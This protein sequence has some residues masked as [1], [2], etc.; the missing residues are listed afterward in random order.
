MESLICIRQGTQN[1]FKVKKV[2][3]NDWCASSPNERMQYPFRWNTRT[4]K[5]CINLIN[6]TSE[7][8]T[9]HRN[10][11]TFLVGMLYPTGFVHLLVKASLLH[12]F[13]QV[14]DLHPANNPLTGPAINMP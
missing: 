4:Y 2:D 1:L 6:T 10:C 9:M 12:H 8:L 5:I 3:E 11:T 13:L 14:T 7:Q